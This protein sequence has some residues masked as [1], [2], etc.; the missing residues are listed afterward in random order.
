MR[1]DQI[2]FL[3]TFP[4]VYTCTSDEFFTMVK[5]HFFA[6]TSFR[7]ICDEI[8]KIDIFGFVHRVYISRKIWCTFLKK[9]YRTV[10]KIFFFSDFDF[11]FCP[12]WCGMVD[13]Y[14]QFSN[15]KIKLQGLLS[16]FKYFFSILILIQGLR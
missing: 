16:F 2:V 1:Q 15:T 8:W 12:I 3:D 9:C 4:T 14:N 13:I 5:V 10:P 6:K 7:Y 11:T